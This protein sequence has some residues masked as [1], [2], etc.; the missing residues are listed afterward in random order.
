MLKEDQKEGF[1][2]V[3]LPSSSLPTPLT[4]VI[5][6]NTLLGV[7]IISPNRALGS[8]TPNWR[9]LLHP[10]PNMAPF[11]VTMTLWLVPEAIDYI[12]WPLIV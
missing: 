9:L 12:L 5:I 1:H 11:I 3:T 7:E 6:A 2:V 8:T 10:N 4:F